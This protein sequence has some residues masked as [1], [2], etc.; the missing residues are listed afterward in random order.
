MSV[1]QAR[2][3]AVYRAL[4]RIGLRIRPA[5]LFVVFAAAGVVVLVILLGPI[6][7]R[8]ASDAVS[9]LT[10]KDRADVIELFSSW[11]GCVGG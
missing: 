8:L 10:G 4:S 5:I 1:S 11:S 6:A 3:A 9:G 2:R 7:N